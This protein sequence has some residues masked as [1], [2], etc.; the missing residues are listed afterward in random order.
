MMY[1]AVE[2][3]APGDFLP[4]EGAWEL[5]DRIPGRPVQLPTINARITR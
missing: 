4:A 3:R 1:S 5:Q 2:E